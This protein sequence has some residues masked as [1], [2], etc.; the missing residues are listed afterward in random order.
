[1]HGARTLRTNGVKKKKK[2]I[3]SKLRK[4]MINLFLKRS[5]VEML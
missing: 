2:K 4:K 5:K 1:M 3:V